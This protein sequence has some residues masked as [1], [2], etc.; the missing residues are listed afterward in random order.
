[1]YCKPIK[2]RYFFYKFSFNNVSIYMYIMRKP[3]QDR[4]YSS[5]ETKKN[6]VID[7]QWQ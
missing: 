2:T 5:R 4:L 7:L 1:M 6:Y 3:I